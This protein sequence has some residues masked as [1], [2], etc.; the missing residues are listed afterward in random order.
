VD[1]DSDFTQESLRL[2]TLQQPLQ[3]LSIFPEK[4]VTYPLLLQSALAEPFQDKTNLS[5]TAPVWEN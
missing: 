1:G 3:I 5:S 2:L 4:A